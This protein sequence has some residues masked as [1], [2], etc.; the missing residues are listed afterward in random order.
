MVEV[1]HS[2]QHEMNTLVLVRSSHGCDPSTTLNLLPLA[3]QK[4]SP[5]T[6]ELN[7]SYLRLINVSSTGI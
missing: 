5:G 4:K 2:S 3:S 7:Q 1:S 6:A